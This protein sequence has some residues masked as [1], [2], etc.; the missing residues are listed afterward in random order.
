[1]KLSLG[2]AAKV[3]GV[4]K[5]TLA[6]M[7]AD[8]RVTG[9]KRPDGVYEID[10]AEV[11]RIARDKDVPRSGKRVEATPAAPE[12]RPEAVDL[13]I[14]KVQLQDVRDRLAEAVRREEQAE[15]R[16]AEALARERALSDRLSRLI[17]DQRPAAPRGL[18][19]RLFGG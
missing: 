8:G 10:K 2:Q 12:A 18:W 13:A 5:T 9:T 6:R 1:V 16:A 4:G 17:E 11:A 7:L 3:A 15:A 19:A 14:L